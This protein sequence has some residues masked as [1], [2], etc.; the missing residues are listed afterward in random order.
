MVHVFAELL[1]CIE[2]DY[3]KKR[4]AIGI[5]RQRVMPNELVVTGWFQRFQKQLVA[6]GLLFGIAER[7]DAVRRKILVRREA[8]LGLM[9]VEI[10]PLAALI[11]Q[12][13]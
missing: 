4:W 9:K 11:Y 3:D 7:T 12:L 1:F 6:L 10:V 2:V 13:P 5:H 8:K